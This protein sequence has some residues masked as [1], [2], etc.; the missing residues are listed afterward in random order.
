MQVPYHKFRQNLKSRCGLYGIRF[1]DYPPGA[2]TPQV[3][4]LNLDPIRQ[5]PYSGGGWLAKSAE[6]RSG[7][8]P[9]R[10][11]GKRITERS[12]PPSAAGEQ[13][14]RITNFK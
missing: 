13:A 5:A 12:L 8:S 6:K 10:T 14:A 9:L 4:A 11:D 3:D 2:S 1:D 7:R